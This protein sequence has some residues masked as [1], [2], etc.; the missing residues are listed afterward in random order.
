MVF[1][2][3]CLPNKNKGIRMN[4]RQE[5]LIAE[6]IDPGRKMPISQAM[7]NWQKKM[8][9]LADALGVEAIVELHED[10]DVRIREMQ[11]AKASEVSIKRLKSLKLFLKSEIEALGGKVVPAKKRKSTSWEVSTKRIAA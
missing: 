11:D 3:R 4:Q 7:E 10:F 2:G 1:Y 6:A 5:D 8:R 9:R